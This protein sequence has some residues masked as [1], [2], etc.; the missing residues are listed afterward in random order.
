M[1]QY[2][3]LIE[4]IINENEDKAREL[5][6]Q[7]VVEKSREIYENIIDE[8]DFDESVDQS[9]QVEDLVNDVDVDNQGLPE[10]EDDEADAGAEE[11]DGDDMGGDD[12]GGDDMGM[13]DMG[14]DEGGSVEDR[15]MDLET[16]LDDLK[17]EFDAL[18]S[19]EGGDDMGMDDMGG[20]DM[21][22]DDMGGDDMGM[23]NDAM[24]RE[25][26]EKVSDGHG[27]EKK[28]AGE[29][30]A[31]G[32]R[33]DSVT[34]A[35]QTKSPGL[36]KANN[37]GGKSFDLGKGTE[38]APDGQRPTGKAGGFLKNPQEIDVAKRNVNKPGGNKGAQ[39]YFSK[40]E[41]SYE[42]AKGAEGQTTDGKLPVN[43]KSLSGG[44]VR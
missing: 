30:K 39:N 23:G 2:E 43:P 31:V 35:T 15:V 11:L 12:M 21:G 27:A 42:K 41:T 18:M 36:Q 32:A 14:G 24:V 20:D 8:T 22:M 13:D 25:Y 16:A 17:A 7:I 10:A 3:K 1:N 33:S 4:F 28:G 6:H 37:M 19:D 34:G 5:F 26:V 38:S 40:K 44:K 29:G 9:D